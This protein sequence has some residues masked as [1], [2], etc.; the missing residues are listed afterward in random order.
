MKSVV[1]YESFYGNTESVA[2]AI[3]EGLARGGPSDA[4]HVGAVDPSMLVDVDLLVVGAPTHVWGLPRARTRSATPA[5]ADA[6]PLLRDWLKSVP[7]GSG[8]PATSF[9]T[10]LDKPRL[11]TGSAAG[12]V[13]RRLKRRGWRIAASPMSFVVGGNEGPL[14]RGQVE[15]AK[16]WGDELVVR[17]SPVHPAP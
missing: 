8:R 11:L 10:R 2:R 7:D 6:G 1:V 9:S 16:A 17:V 13:A 4:V 3:A 12:G 15:Q 5:A 14:E